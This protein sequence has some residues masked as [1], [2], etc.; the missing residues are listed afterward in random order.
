L[1][2][3]SRH[4]SIRI[5]MEHSQPAGSQVVEIEALADSLFKGHSPLCQFVEQGYNGTH[6]WA[7]FQADVPLSEAVLCFTCDAGLWI[8]R[9]WQKAAATLDRTIVRAIIPD[10]T[11]AFFFNVKD[12]RG[13]ISSSE[14]IQITQ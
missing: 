14:M 13:L 7:K 2:T 9:Q 12:E 10:G 1:P 8:P 6:A 5:G 11:T 3:T 4:L